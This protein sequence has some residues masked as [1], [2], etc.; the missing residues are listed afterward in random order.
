MDVA[1]GM[2]FSIMIMSS[3][4]ITTAGSLHAKG[5]TDI[6]TAEEDAKALQPLVKKFPYSVEIAE[7]IF[8]LGIIDT[9]LLAIPILAGSSAYAISDTLSWKQGL[10]N[11]FKQAKPFYLVIAVSTLIGLG[12]NFVNIDPIKAPTE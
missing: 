1:V 6:S 7:V 10:G 12:I 8:A 11:K 5:V 4:M 9:G 3:I 2:A